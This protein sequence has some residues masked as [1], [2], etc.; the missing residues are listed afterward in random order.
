MSAP[1]TNFD[2]VSILGFERGDSS[3]IPAA[4]PILDPSQARVVALGDDQSAA[5]LGAPG[6]GK[7]TTIIE[8]VADRVR[9]RVDPAG[10][11]HRRPEA[12]G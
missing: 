2:R 4:P 5:V 12:D 6:S 8:L 7:T 3:A 11:T 9:D 1:S 10:A